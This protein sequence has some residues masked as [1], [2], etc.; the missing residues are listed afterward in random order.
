M[1]FGDTMSNFFGVG[2]GDPGNDARNSLQQ[3]GQALNGQ[4]QQLGGYGQQWANA[5]NQNQGG[6][7]N[8]IGM[9]QQ[10]ANGQNSVS[11]M[12]L[13]QGLMQANAAQQAMAAGAAPANAAMAARNAA[14]GMGNMSTNLMGQQ[15][16]AG[17][18]ERNAAVN[19]LGGLQ[20][21][22][23]Q[24]NLQ[25]SLGAYGAANQ[26]YGNANQAYGTVLQ[27]P[28]K[29]W[30]QNVIAPAAAGGLQ[31]AGM[32]MGGPAGAAAGGA[33]TNWQGAKGST[34]ASPY[35]GGY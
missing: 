19:A 35:P 23:A 27:N 8:T 18:Q 26:A 20:A 15:A 1:G 34:Y 13:Q 17:Q 32:A 3:N 7:N 9:L 29:S 24:M 4:A 25:G 21:Q 33:A 11:A 16:V 31:A 6:I 5:F 14:M 12:Q 10:Q 28:Q 30:W 2:S 22:Q